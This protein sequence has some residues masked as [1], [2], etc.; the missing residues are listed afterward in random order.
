MSP[1]PIIDAHVH[2]WEPRR[3]AMPWLDG[4]PTLDQTYLLPEFHAH[5]QGVALEA[6]VY[7]EVGM[8]PAYALAEARFVAQLAQTEPR[9]RGIVAF[10]PVEDGLHLRGFLDALVATS[11]LVKGVRRMLQ[12]E[13]DAAICL[14]PDFIAGVQLLPAYGLTFD[15]CITHGQLEPATELVRRCPETQ[16]ML[17]HIA[18]PAISRGELD[19]WRTQL[20]ALAAL[21]N[22]MCKISGLVTEADRAN[23]QPADL[24]PYVAH[25]LD[26]FGED[27]VAFGGDWPVALLA[28][29]YPR[30]VETLDALTSKLSA[31][32]QHKLWAENARRFYGL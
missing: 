31:E 23:W 29:T 15:L 9:L 24:A 18:K 1:V 8:N 7:V 2:L 28:A 13:A 11:P 16:F 30:W 10:A 17:D 19:P 26:V 5:T 21:P 12:G 14:Q 4:D 20:A 32:A 3:F 27:W 25:V 22:V 6:F